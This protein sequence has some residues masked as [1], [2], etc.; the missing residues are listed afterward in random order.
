MKSKESLNR[1]GIA[2]VWTLA[3]AAFILIA[4]FMAVGFERQASAADVWADGVKQTDW[5]NDKPGVTNAITQM[6]VTNDTQTANDTAISNLVDKLEALTN[7]LEY[8]SW[9]LREPTN[10][11][12]HFFRSP[13]PRAVT[14]AEVFCQTRSGTGELD[15]VQKGF[16]ATWDSYTVYIE[17]NV[18]ADTDGTTDSSIAGTAAVSNGDYIG[19]IPNSVSFIHD[20]NVWVVGVGIS[21]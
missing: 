18:V 3:A 20:T 12:P 6:G 2:V 8:Y 4:V 13:W 7:K 21:P 10:D 19:F 16:A 5:Q 11:M 14:I 17:S 9:I 1:V 15:I